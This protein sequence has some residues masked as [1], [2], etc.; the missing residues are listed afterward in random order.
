[1]STNGWVAH[2][3]THRIRPDL[4]ICRLQAYKVLLA[5]APEYV[6]H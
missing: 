4:V 1:M 3:M 2:K 5:S 6:T